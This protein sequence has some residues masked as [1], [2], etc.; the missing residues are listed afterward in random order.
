MNLYDS[1]TDKE[2]VRFFSER[3]GPLGTDTEF[4]TW[5]PNRKSVGEFILREEGFTEYDGFCKECY[6][7]SI[8]KKYKFFT[9]IL[10]GVNED[11]FY[12]EVCKDRH[13]RWSVEGG[14]IEDMKYLFI[15]P[16]DRSHTDCCLPHYRKFREEYSRLIDEE[17]SSS[18]FDDSYDDSETELDISSDFYEHVEAYYMEQERLHNEEYKIFLAEQEEL[19]RKDREAFEKSMNTPPD[20]HL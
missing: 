19:K 11:S 15:D 6:R 7:S 10:E 8:K 12:C 5:H 13:P 2:N 16:E 1:V 3:K 18:V 17:D 20:P 9:S 4:C 14:E